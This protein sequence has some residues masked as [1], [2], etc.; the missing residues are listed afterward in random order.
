MCAYRIVRMSSTFCMRTINAH[1][2]LYARLKLL[3]RACRAPFLYA[4]MVSG[5]KIQ[6]RC[7]PTPDPVEEG[8]A[9]EPAGRKQISREGE[10]RGET[11][12][13]PTCTEEQDEP[14][15]EPDVETRV[16][17]GQTRAPS[18]STPT[19]PYSWRGVQCLAPLQGGLPASL[20]GQSPILCFAELQ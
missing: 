20:T 18:K 16:E 5:I 2:E 3:K 7:S 11:E 6:R 14:R 12:D 4:H 1:T 13:P 10:P 8:T 15:T 19:C 9:R 17:T